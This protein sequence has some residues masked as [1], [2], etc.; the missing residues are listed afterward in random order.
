VIPVKYSE[1][2][3]LFELDL[4][5]LNVNGIKYEVHSEYSEIDSLTKI[6]RVD[7]YIFSD[8]LQSTWKDYV[9]LLFMGHLIMN[10]P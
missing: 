6:A 2:C 5:I 9:T 4:A 8:V 7:V 1:V 3:A 10:R